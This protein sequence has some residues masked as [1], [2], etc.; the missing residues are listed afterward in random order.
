MR[1]FL[2]LLH[3]FT[4]NCLISEP[5]SCFSRTP[6]SMWGS[7]R[8]MAGSIEEGGRSRDGQRVGGSRDKT[9]RVFPKDTL[10]DKLTLV[11]SC[12]RPAFLHSPLLA[13]VNSWGLS[14]RVAG[15][16]GPPDWE[17]GWDYSCAVSLNCR[18]LNAWIWNWVFSLACEKK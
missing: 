18:N 6:A 5:T 10:T 12:G 15:L 2:Y 8:S 11:L 3:F 14:R 4:V 13:G 1:A 9:L 7:W 17:V 16:G